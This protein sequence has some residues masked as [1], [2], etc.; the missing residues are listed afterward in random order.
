MP[1]YPY[2]TIRIERQLVGRITDMIIEDADVIRLIEEGD[3][4]KIRQI[5]GF[6]LLENIKRL[7][8]FDE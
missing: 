5:M 3:Q 4:V 1:F 6:R 7:Y 8:I 2:H